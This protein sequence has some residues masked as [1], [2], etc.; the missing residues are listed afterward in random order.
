MSETGLIIPY[1]SIE[2]MKR[3]LPIEI[4]F[5]N[6]VNKTDSCWLWTG[7]LRSGY[8]AF[9]I[10]KKTFGSHRISFTLF[11]GEIPE[12]NIICHTCDVRTCLNP[13]HLVLGTHKYNTQ[14]ML[15]KGRVDTKKRCASQIKHPSINQYKKGCRCA[16]CKAL[17][18]AYVKKYKSGKQPIQ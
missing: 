12:G 2:I 7:S 14:D 10:N 3:K 9:S 11:N 13:A 4:L 5:F 15:K 6:H 1:K 18:A 17:K 8:G 16:E